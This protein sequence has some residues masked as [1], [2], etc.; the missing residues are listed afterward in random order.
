MCAQVPEHPEP[1]TSSVTS[2][3]TRSFSGVFDTSP[4]TAG[5]RFLSVK[6]FI[7]RA[8][9]LEPRGSVPNHAVP[10]L[11]CILLTVFI[12]QPEPAPSVHSQTITCIIFS[13][14][15]FNVQRTK[16]NMH[17]TDAFINTQLKLHAY[18]LILKECMWVQFP[19][20]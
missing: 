14:R 20:N 11:R 4:H 12:C 9:L 16:K 10:V 7:L 17:L 5:S 1:S 8:T 15:F 13:S 6:H 2:A 18:G 19:R 3:L